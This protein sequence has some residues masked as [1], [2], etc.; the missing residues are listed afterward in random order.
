MN[1][2]GEPYL[3]LTIYRARVVGVF[4]VRQLFGDSGEP[5]RIC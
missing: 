1:I 5:T 4:K 3:G 2:S